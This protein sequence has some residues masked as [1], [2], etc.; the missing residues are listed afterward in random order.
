VDVAPLDTIDLAGGFQQKN[1]AGPLDRIEVYRVGSRGFNPDEYLVM[2]APR[3]GATAT[4][5]DHNT[6]F[7]AGGKGDGG[8]SPRTEVIVETV[9]CKDNDGSQQCYRVPR[10]FSGRTPDLDASRAGQSAV[11]DATR[12]LFLV[13]GVSDANVTPDPILYNPE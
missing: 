6:I 7:I 2:A 5:L 12:R 9:E 3:G 8:V 13:G 11:F 1:A 4:L 10:L